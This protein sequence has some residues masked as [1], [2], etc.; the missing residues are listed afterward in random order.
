MKLEP[1][2]W[3]LKSKYL[4]EYHDTYWGIPEYD[5]LKL[6][7]ML[8]LEGQQAGLSWDLILRKQ[9]AMLKAYDNFDP[10]ILS[11]YDE[12]KII[13]LKSNPD[14]IR[15]KLKIKAAISNAKAYY[16]LIKYHQSLK[17]FIWGHVAYQPIINYYNSP[18]AVPTTTALS[19]EISLKLKKLGFKF[20]GS[21]TIQS[22]LEACG[23][24]NNHLTNCPCHPNNKKG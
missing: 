18:K 5:E 7:Q 6:F 17:D 22:Y 13:E 19:D 1:C 11:K 15:N 20:V 4:Q 23:I 21:I 24:Y 3:A 2:P 10:A 9:S 14:I 12:S 8:I 16:E